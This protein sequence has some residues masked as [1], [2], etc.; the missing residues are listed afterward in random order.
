MDQLHYE[1]MLDNVLELERNGV[2]CGAVIIVFGHCNASEE[3]IDL[4]LEKGYVVKCLLDNNKEKQG[5]NYRGVPI[6]PPES[7]LDV[8]GEK[9]IVCV[10]T[11]FYE[12]M[13]LQLRKMGFTG[14]VR[15]LIDYNTYAE[16]SLSEETIVRK[17]QRVERGQVLLTELDKKYPESFRIFCPFSALGDVY[18][19]M[20]YL[21]YFL[22]KKDAAK[23]VISVVG[24]ACAQV[25]RLFM[26]SISDNGQFASVDYQVEVY[27]QKDMDEMIQAALYIED[28]QSFIA[29]QDRPYVVNLHK[30]LYVKCIPLEQIYCCGVFGL[31]LGTKPYKPANLEKYRDID[32]I[33]KGNAVIFSPYAKSVT[34]FNEYFWK[35][36]VNDYLQRGFQCLTNVVGD[37][38]ALEGTVPISPSILEIQ[39]VVEKAGHF[40]GIRSGLCDVIR[41]ADCK[42]IALYPDYYYSD[43]KWK[44]IDMYALEGW[45]NIVVGENFKWK[46]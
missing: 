25:I 39:S 41:Y 22:K 31:P 19:M 37:E 20:S 42:K 14:A 44:A 38:K 6:F 17:K 27:S 26:P 35:E 46:S 1:E 8:N 12:A 43:T 7:I 9:T 15:K 23:C 18:I 24:N 13:N 11:R 16:Y 5:E 34:T 30:A 4:L 32:L 2:F 10:V 40:V 45:E 33:E 3:L 21:P 29:H 36:I 28:K